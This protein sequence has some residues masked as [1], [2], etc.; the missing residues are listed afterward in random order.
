MS[1]NN[2]HYWAIQQDGSEVY[3][4]GVAC[5]SGELYTLPTVAIRYRAALEG[6]VTKDEAMWW[7][8]FLTMFLT[9]LPFTYEVIEEGGKSYIMWTL[10]SLHKLRPHNVMY[11]TA[12][13]YPDEYYGI[14]HAMYARREKCAG[15]KELFAAFYEESKKDRGDNHTLMYFGYGA[16]ATPRAIT[17]EEFA[18]NLK[19]GCGSVYGYFKPPAGSKPEKAV[20]LAPVVENRPVVEAKPAAEAKPAVPYQ[21]AYNPPRVAEADI[22]VPMVAPANGRMPVPPDK[23]DA[24]D[25]VCLP[26]GWRSAYGDLYLYPGVTMDMWVEHRGENLF[27]NGLAGHTAQGIAG[28]DEDHG[29]LWRRVP[30]PA[31]N[32][33]FVKVDGFSDVYRFDGAAKAVFNAYVVAPKRRKRAPIPVDLVAYLEYQPL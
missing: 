6:G 1:S 7:G 13:R 9:D 32:V 17:T 28:R 26:D 24:K 21:P 16:S 23:R 19:S 5:F 10:K 20:D 3:H 33:G 25:W 14:V 2:V 31:A 15:L 30:A 18:M 27:V 29:T 11:C 12:F 8:D 22:P 4:G